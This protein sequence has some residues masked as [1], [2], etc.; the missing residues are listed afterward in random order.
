MTKDFIENLLLQV[1]AI[2]FYFISRDVK[3]IF[4]QRSK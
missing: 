3:S 1:I 4:K 2:T